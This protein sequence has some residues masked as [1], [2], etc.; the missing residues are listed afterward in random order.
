M[1]L[2]ENRWGVVGLAE[3]RTLK[4]GV[5]G[6][7][8]VVDGGGGAGRGV[9]VVVVGGGGGWWRWGVRRESDMWRAIR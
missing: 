9:W 6:L 5:V 3:H 8:V 1:R 2:V 4:Q 7:V